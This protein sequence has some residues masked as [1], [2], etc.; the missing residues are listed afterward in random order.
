[1]ASSSTLSYLHLGRPET[2]L[3]NTV[4]NLETF[5]SEE[6]EGKLDAQERGGPKLSIQKDRLRHL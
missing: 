3:I 5:F 2:I 4:E 6:S 1:L